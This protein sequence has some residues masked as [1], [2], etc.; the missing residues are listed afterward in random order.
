MLSSIHWDTKE[1]P[2][3]SGKRYVHVRIQLCFNFSQDP[4]LRGTTLNKHI[5]L[6]IDMRYYDWSQL[7]INLGA[8]VR[9]H[10][11]VAAETIVVVVLDSADNLEREDG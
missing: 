9:V 4:R 5:Y 11:H 10:T 6:V 7:N 2:H 8:Y 3:L 1:T